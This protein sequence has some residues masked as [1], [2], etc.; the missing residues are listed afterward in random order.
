MSKGIRFKKNN[1]N[2]FVD[3]YY[4]VGDLYLTTR[5][6]N[7]STIFGGTWELFGP[8]RTL[9]CVDTSQSEFN[10][11][12]K[13]GGSK[14]LQSHNHEGLYALYG[15]SAEF[16]CG[17][18]SNSSNNGYNL[19]YTKGTNGNGYFKVGTTGTGNSENLQPF[20]I[21]YIWIRTT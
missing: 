13:T 21:C 18:N 8:G 12:K 4:R 16:E 14:Y 6:E 7:P 1:E 15:D 11:V 3:R 19:T 10:T 17:L 9:V 5:S 20:I 2:A